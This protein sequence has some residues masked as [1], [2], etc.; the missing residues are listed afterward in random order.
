MEDGSHSHSSTPTTG[1]AAGDDDVQVPGCSQSS[2]QAN[3]NKTAR[4][5]PLVIQNSTDLHRT[6]SVPQIMLTPL[7]E[8][9]YITLPQLPSTLIGNLPS[10]GSTSSNKTEN[11]ILR[12]PLYSLAP[13]IIPSTFQAAPS[14]SPCTSSCFWSSSINFHNMQDTPGFECS[15]GAVTLGNYPAFLYSPAL[16]LQ[17]QALVSATCNQQAELNRKRKAFEAGLDYNVHTDQPDGIPDKKECQN[18]SGGVS[19]SRRRLDSEPGEEPQEV[20]SGESLLEAGNESEDENEE[21]EDENDQEEGEEE[22]EEEETEDT[23]AEDRN[24]DINLIIVVNVGSNEAIANEHRPGSSSTS[25]VA[26]PAVEATTE[27]AQ[28]V[29]QPVT[30]DN[31]SDNNQSTQSAPTATTTNERLLQA[32]RE[33]LSTPVL[34]GESEYE[35]Y[36][37]LDEDEENNGDEDDDDNEEEQEQAAVPLNTIK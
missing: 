30:N 34:G 28:R 24:K 13:S 17:N 7:Q 14:P 5:E 27:S 22:E 29:E 12:A 6:E 9:G 36:E 4:Q 8:V 15:T 32:I 10:T 21:E 26:M 33:A 3:D 37:P 16:E 2:H 23:T 1:G 25:S 35:E 11:N 20:E 31:N 19:N 18:C